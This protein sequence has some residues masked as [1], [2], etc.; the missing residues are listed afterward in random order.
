MK[1]SEILKEQPISTKYSTF[2]KFENKKIID[3]IYDENKEKNVIKILE[4]KYEELFIIY[5]IK[6]GDSEDKRKLEKI[7][8]K[9]EG[10]DFLEEKNIC[11]GIE[12]L[13]EELKK[14]HEE[15]YIEKVKTACLGYKSY[16]IN[17][18]D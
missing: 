14:N 15:E 18:K 17:K 9:I 4:L 2:D 16:F 3:K 10:L 7:K 5:R 1:I 8:D 6:L 12:K 13:I 11:N